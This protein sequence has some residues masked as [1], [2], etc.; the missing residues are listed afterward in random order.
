[1]NFFG[2]AVVASWADRQ[3]GHL[4]G[5][6][7]PDFE[8][9]IG[10]PLLEVRDR[11]IQRG[12]DLHHRTDEAFHRAP[13]FLALCAHALEALIDAGVR[14][15]TAR[16]VGHVGSEMFLDGWLV[17]EQ[18]HIDDYLAAL[19]LD[20]NELLCWRD[21]GLAFSKLKAR[22][23]I[24]GAP[25]DYADAPFVLARLTDAFRARP[26]LAVHADQADPVAKYLPSLQ[27]MVEHRAPELLNELQDALGLAD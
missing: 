1:M 19:E 16:A 25:S 24:W 11:D 13:V 9:M 27:Q 26:A 23:T 8:A 20:A 3:A 10:V 14:R 4:L 22:L 15:G 2:H 7:L 18:G 21:Q 5:S 6:M 12:I 17:R